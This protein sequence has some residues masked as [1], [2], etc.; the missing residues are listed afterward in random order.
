VSVPP[1]GAFRAALRRPQQLLASW[2]VGAFQVPGLAERVFAPPPGQPWSPALVRMLVGSG[3]SRDRAE[4]DAAAMAEPGALTAALNW[5]RA[6][7]LAWREAAA[8]I[9]VPALYVWSDR[10]PALTRAAA[11]R[12]PEHVAGPFRFVEL[13]GVSHWIPEEAPDALAALLLDHVGA[14]PVR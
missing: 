14:H 12:A 1:P 5:Y 4:R 3:Q 2:Y 13:P 8:P 10:D 7:P 9:T 6:L 11:E